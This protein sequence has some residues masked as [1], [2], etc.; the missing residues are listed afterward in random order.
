MLTVEALFKQFDGHLARRG[1]IERGGQILDGEPLERRHHRR[2][3]HAWVAPLQKL[4]SIRH[5]VGRGH[6]CGVRDAV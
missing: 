1:Y 4:C 3:D 2:S 5:P 6:V